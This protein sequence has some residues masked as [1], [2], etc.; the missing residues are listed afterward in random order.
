[1]VRPWVTL[2]LIVWLLNGAPVGAQ[3]AGDCDDSG[4]VAV[5]ELVIG[6]NIALERAGL[7]RCASFDAND[8][9]RVAVNE[10]VA[11]V[12][13]ALRG[14]GFV[15]QYAATVALDGGAT[16]TIELM[17]TANGEATGTLIISEP[18]ALG[19]AQGTTSVNISGAF[20]P[21][22]GSFLVTG[23]FQGPNGTINVRI[24]GQLGGAFMLQ[25]GD[26]VYN[27][28]FGARPT[29]TPTPTRTAVGPV[30]II[31]VGN[32]VLPFD[33]EVLEINPGETVMWMW[34]G[35]PH[36][37]RSAQLN[38]IQQPS[39][40]ASGLFDS[41][42]QSAGTFSY[43]FTTPGRYGFHCGVETHCEENFESGYID[44]R[45]T[46]TATPTRTWT[47]SPTIAIPTSTPTPETIG[48]VSTRMLGFFSGTVTY[49]T[50]TP[51]PARLQIQVNN[52]EVTVTDV[53]GNTGI[54]PNPVTMT[55]ESPTSLSYELAGPPPITF[56]LSLN[57]QGHV[58]G[59]YSVNDPIMP[60]LPADFDLIREE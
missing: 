1:M 22:T 25:I 9:Q 7:D 32:P 6:V 54:F 43:T 41:G 29:A 12:N 36:S 38:A 20:D 26:R 40:I 27:S 56:T 14:C 45:G 53:M 37:V 13:N 52:N 34:I 42:V 8:D 28:S 57:A 21:A 46:P 18:A 10:L 23:T 33:P 48:G 17:A 59:R 55:V 39:C 35:G 60:R 2:T 3:C 15:G 30:H 58:V 31:T 5:N 44:V 50:Q 47:P 16:G 11:A 24:S 49:G 51:L 19:Q 4:A